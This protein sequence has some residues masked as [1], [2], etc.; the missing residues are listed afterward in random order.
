MS[1]TSETIFSIRDSSGNA[2][3]KIPDNSV[4]V[5][6]I[7]DLW[8][9]II[10]YFDNHLFVVGKF[11]V[12][13][14]DYRL[15]TKSDL[16]NDELKILFAYLYRLNNGILSLMNISDGNKLGHPVYC[17]DYPDNSCLL[18]FDGKYIHV[19]SLQDSKNDIITLYARNT[20]INAFCDNIEKMKIL[21]GWKHGSKVFGLFIRKD[22][23]V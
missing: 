10:K 12:P 11:H 4:L 19:S 9:C 20:D 6:I 16:E 22:Y 7:P 5:N 3:L 21:Y 15:V 2:L 18:S 17:D 1:I 13:Y 23:V 8:S 14:D